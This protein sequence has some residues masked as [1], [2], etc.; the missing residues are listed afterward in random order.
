[1]PVD[2]HFPFEYDDALTGLGKRGSAA[3]QQDV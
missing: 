2:V 3:G 1:V